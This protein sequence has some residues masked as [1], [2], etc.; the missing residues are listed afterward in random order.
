[1]AERR[2]RLGALPAGAFD[3]RPGPGG[4]LAGLRQARGPQ[5]RHSH[6]GRREAVRGGGQPTVHRLVRAEH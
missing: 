2:P 1:M 6:P 5:P 4:G 3:L